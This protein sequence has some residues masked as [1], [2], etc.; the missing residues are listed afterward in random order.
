M[1]SVDKDER[2]SQTA[3]NSETTNRQAAA[4]TRIFELKNS[5]CL[6][7]SQAVGRSALSRKLDRKRVMNTGLICISGEFLTAER[8]RAR[9]SRWAASSLRQAAQFSRCRK[10]S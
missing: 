2:L 5:A 3:P 1:V 10:T 4:N 6:N 7:F 9:K 8:T